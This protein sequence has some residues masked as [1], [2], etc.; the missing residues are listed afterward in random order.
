ML[1]AR[2]LLVGSLPLLAALPLALAT[3]GPSVPGR[4]D[5]ERISQG[6]DRAVPASLTMPGG[7]SPEARS[8]PTVP[9]TGGE[10]PEDC[11]V[12]NQ[13]IDSTHVPPMLCTKW[14]CKDGRT[15]TDCEPI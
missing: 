3:E 9:A 4:A 5:A 2:K 10:A 7:L 8:Q 13:W 1:R 11:V 12:I 15:W 14:L 6:P